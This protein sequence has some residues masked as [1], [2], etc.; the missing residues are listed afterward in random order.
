MTE[1]LPVIPIDRLSLCFAPR[2][3]P[4]AERKRTEIAAHFAALKREKPDLWNGPV[5]LLYE[6]RIEERAFHGVFLRTDFASFIAW[7][8]WGFPDRSVKNCFALGALQASDDAFLLGIMAAAT[9]NAGKI[10]FPGGTPD[11][12]DVRGD[13]VDLEGS[14]RREVAEETG[15]PPHELA[16]ATGWRMVRAEGRIALLKHMR[17]GEAAD[18]LRA[19]IRAT[20]AQQAHPEL[21]DIYVARGLADLDPNMPDFVR[22]FLKYEWRGRQA[23][24]RGEPP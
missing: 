13:T 11:L 2:P 15:I 18:V 22:A 1:A 9:A 6:Y 3:W 24:R 12:D 5:L 23:L 7:R 19:R 10:Y 21:A 8:D 16:I 4:F 17:A 20:L 14:V